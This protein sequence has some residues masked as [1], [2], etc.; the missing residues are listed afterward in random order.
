MGEGRGKGVSPFCSKIKEFFFSFRRGLFQG[1]R[2]SGL[3]STWG[4]TSRDWLGWCGEAS[5]E[6]LPPQSGLVWGFGSPIPLQGN[7]G[8]STMNPKDHISEP[9]LLWPP[10]PS[11]WVLRWKALCYPG[12]SIRLLTFFEKQW[13]DLLPRVPPRSEVSSKSLMTNSLLDKAQFL[14]LRLSSE[15][16]GLSGDWAPSGCMGNSLLSGRINQTGHSPFLIKDRPAWK[17]QH[18]QS[19]LGKIYLNSSKNVL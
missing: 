8:H 4:L 9:L 12:V 19:F 5:L 1:T 2:S 7:S 3:L 15:T 6:P 14:G 16:Q 11:L 13:A 10:G 17:K 18:Q